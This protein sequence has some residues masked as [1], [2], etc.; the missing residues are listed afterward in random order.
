M[1]HHALLNE[2]HPKRQAALEAGLS[3]Y[4]YSTVR[5]VEMAG[6][7][8]WGDNEGIRFQ[9]LEVTLA[10]GRTLAVVFKRLLPDPDP[11]GD[12]CLREVLIYRRLLA[13][14]RFGA[15][16]LY[17]S[18]QDEV[19]ERY[20]PFFDDLGDQSLDDG[21]S[22]DW[23]AAARWLAKL[24]AAYAGREDELR[25][26][27][28][29]GEHDSRG[30]CTTAGPRSQSRRMSRSYAAMASE[31]IPRSWPTP[32]NAATSYAR[33]GTSAIQ[34]FAGIPLASKSFSTTWRQPDNHA[35][36]KQ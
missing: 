23:N 35:A 32:R 5:I 19:R 11:V 16:A 8:L 17:A 22:E 33:H 30:C 28:C 27:G 9:R 18:V 1:T 31:G 15:P 6:T 26:L 21:A 3:N 4:F 10:S 34:K 24:H 13:R 20:W 14:G 36:R 2:T 29:L 25:N 12:P 7:P